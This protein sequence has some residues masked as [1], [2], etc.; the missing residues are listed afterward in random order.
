MRIKAFALGIWEFRTA[1]TTHYNDYTLLEW[2]DRGRE[3][4]HKATFR[5]FEQ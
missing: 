2:Y 1:F 4:T 3:L 5:R